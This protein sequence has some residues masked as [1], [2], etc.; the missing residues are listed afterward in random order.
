MSLA[1]ELEKLRQLHKEGA[2]TAEEYTQAKKRLLDGDA[3]ATSAVPPRPAAPPDVSLRVGLD[4]KLTNMAQQ[5]SNRNLVG[6]VIS[7][8]VVLVFLSIFGF[9]AC[10]ISDAADACPP[11]STCD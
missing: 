11:Y 1:D 8:V 3:P 2:L 6:H 9:V 4:P 5:A 10:S 7:G